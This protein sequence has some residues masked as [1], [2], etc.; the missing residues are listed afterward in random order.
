[1]S[2]H[3]RRIGLLDAPSRLR[4]LGSSV[5]GLGIDLQGSLLR[6]GVATVPT[7]FGLSGAGGLV[8][9]PVRKEASRERT[10][11]LEC[12][13]S[14]WDLYSSGIIESRRKSWGASPFLGVV[15]R[16]VLLK[17]PKFKVTPGR[18][19]ENQW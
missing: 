13:S 15:L 9:C 12:I 19:S 18:L 16:H 7:N 5:E 1:M 14:Y 17:V 3:E 4:T 8:R 6:Y 2:F 10:Y 11:T